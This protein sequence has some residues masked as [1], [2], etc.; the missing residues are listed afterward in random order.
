LNIRSDGGLRGASILIAEFIDTA[1][2][3]YTASLSVARL[4]GELCD[5]FADSTVQLG[6]WW[7]S[8]EFRPGVA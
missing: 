3:L 1:H 6:V 7:K 4:A 5:K 2:R 8:R